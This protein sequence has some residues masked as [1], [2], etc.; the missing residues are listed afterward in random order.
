MLILNRKAGESIMIDDRIEI[1]VLEM[2][3]GKIKIGIEAP[4]N[5]S[6]L[7]KEVFDDIKNENAQAANVSMDSFSKLKNL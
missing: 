3:D 4:K 6:I 5:I 2:G 1:K 7:R